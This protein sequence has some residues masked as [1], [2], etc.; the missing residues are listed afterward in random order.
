MIVLHLFNN[1]IVNGNF[2]LY[3]NN[4]KMSTTKNIQKCIKGDFNF[5]IIIIAKIVQT[6]EI[7]NGCYKGNSIY[8]QV[9]LERLTE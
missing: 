6:G 7:V 9:L 8:I 4:T 3:T 1:L 2:S 5:Y